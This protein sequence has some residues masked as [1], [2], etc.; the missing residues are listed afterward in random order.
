MNDSLENTKETEAAWEALEKKCSDC[1]GCSL[2]KTKTNTVFGCGNK[3]ARVMFIGEAPGE[4]EDK[5]GIPFVARRDNCLTAILTQ[6]AFRAKA[7][8]LPTS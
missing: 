3:N 7:S 6:L 8:I 5:Q 2:Y 4:S 1:T